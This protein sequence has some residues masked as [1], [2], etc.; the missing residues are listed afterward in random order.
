MF[1]D[2]A[3]LLS[4]KE[5]IKSTMGQPAAAV[6]DDNP[7]DTA[8]GAAPG[9][10]GR[11]GVST[12]PITPVRGDDATVVDVAT[13]GP[14]LKL[15]WV[16]RR[17][18]LEGS[19]LTLDSLDALELSGARC[20]PRG[21]GGL[22]LRLPGGR[23]VLLWS[24]RKDDAK[25]LDAVAGACA[26][27]TVEDL[28]AACREAAP[29]GPATPPQRLLLG[30][31]Q[32][33]A[34]AAATDANDAADDGDDADAGADVCPVCLEALWRRPVAFFADA[35]RGRACSHF[36]HANCAAEIAA[37]GGTTCPT[38]RAP[39]SRPRAMPPLDYADLAWVSTLSDANGVRR[40]DACAALA[41]QF[42]FDRAAVE[43][44]LP[45]DSWGGEVLDAAKLCDVR[46]GIRAALLGPKPASPCS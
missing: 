44:D 7:V 26:P 35:R 2:G 41:A 21:G 32:E 3:G 11:R 36:L 12:A 16:R 20:T 25:L 14:G 42:P 19:K 10:S 34:A 29:T 39:F 23:R 1:V 28:V 17:A 9:D 27:P 13:T 46:T 33:T 6:A 30:R 43:D 24:P 5:T 22:R 37:R 8:P 38:C 31:C 45:W 18:S 40:R 4:A 15:Q